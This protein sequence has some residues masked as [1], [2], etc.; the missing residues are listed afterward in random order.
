MTRLIRALIDT[1]ALRHNLGTIRAYAPGA[2]VMAVVKANA[3]GHG[4][5]STAL[6][7]ADADAFAVARLE[8]GIVLRGAGVRA[9]I[10]LLEGVFSAEQLAEAAHHGFE[11][12]VH[13]PLQLKLLEAH[14]GP[15]RFTVWIKVD[16]GM[17]RLGFRPEAFPAALLR[18]RAL[19]VPALE[20]RLMTHLARADEREVWMT[21]EQVAAFEHVIAG[22]GL[23]G[24]RKLATSI[25]NSAGIL[26]WPNAHGDWVRPGLALYGVSPFGAETADRHGLKPVMTLETTVITVRDVKQGETVGYAGAWRAE[27]DS[28]IAILA[29]GY[30]DGLPRHLANDTPVLIGGARYPLVGRVSMDMIAVDVTGAAR[31]A[32]GNRAVIWGADLPVEEVARHADTIPYELLCGVSQRVPIELK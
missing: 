4:L 9:P 2:K 18:L 20:L 10:V 8:E 1:A 32:T 21:R 16:T 22:A 14:R 17:N 3:Y 28:A 7:L 11:L 27:R 25:G 24:A 23:A 13:D 26:G 30:G 31:V 12:V 15:E 5:V 19:T 29:A 6:A